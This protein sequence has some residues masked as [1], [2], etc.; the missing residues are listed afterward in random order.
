MNIGDKV[1]VVHGKEEGVVV[2]FTSKGL[3]EVMLVDGFRIPFSR[4][5]L[6]VVSNLEAKVF[7]P[8]PEDQVARTAKA[9]VFSDK[10]IFLAKSVET[11]GKH[12]FHLINNTDYQ[13]LFT[14]HLARPSQD[15]KALAAG[16]LN[17]KTSIQVF[18]TEQASM[19][20]D[21][22]MVC[23]L[24]FFVQGRN[25]IRLP[26]VKELELK[27]AKWKGDVESLPVLNKKGTKVQL[28]ISLDEKEV[29]AI[30]SALSEKIPVHQSP[31][32]KPQPELDLHIEKI[33]PNHFSLLPDEMLRYQMRAFEN[34]L[35]KAISAGLKEV[36]YIHGVG[37]GVLKSEIAKKLSTNI[38]VRHYEDAR[39]DKYGYGA[40]KV[41]LK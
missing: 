32:T 15:V 23:Q 17:K 20:E 19:L 40:T 13:L 36:T 24:L 8:E 37:N 38:F 9:Q 3:V 35:E 10:G 26:L 25:E 5:D 33:V 2:G 16:S 6:V 22:R 1:R 39:K 7:M 30:E 29:K 31:H 11:D 34:H 27:V 21:G 12:A 14:T 28:D 18:Q 41:V 4:A